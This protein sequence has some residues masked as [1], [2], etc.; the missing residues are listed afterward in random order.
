MLLVSDHSSYNDPMVLAATAGRPPI[1]LTAREVYESLVLNWL[2]QTAFYIPVNRGTQDVGA[3]RAMLRALGRGEVIALFPEGGI[4]EHR[5]EEGHLGIGYLALKSGAPIVPASIAWDS[6]RPPTLGRSLLTPGKVSVRYGEP[7]VLPPGTPTDRHNI[8]L[9]T[10]RIMQ[11][12][13]DLQNQE[14]G[15][16]P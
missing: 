10:D 3:V 7:I 14:S 8:S 5:Q 1:F 13:R 9:V 4:D 16:S 11:A 12:I 15:T 6:P 2:C